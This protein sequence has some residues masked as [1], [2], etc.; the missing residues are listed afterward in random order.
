[1]KY[2]IEWYRAKTEREYK[3]STL[4][5]QKRRTEIEIRQLS[6]GNPYNDK[7]RQLSSDGY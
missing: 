3:E 2:Q 4:E 5:E 7:I 1:M 6:D